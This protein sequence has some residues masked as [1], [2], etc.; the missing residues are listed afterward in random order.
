MPAISAK[1]ILGAA[2]LG[3]DIVRPRAPI[4]TARSVVR[5][6]AAKNHLAHQWTVAKRK[7]VTTRT[8]P[9]PRIKP[10][11]PGA[12]RSSNPVTSTLMVTI[13]PTMVSAKRKP[14]LTSANQATVAPQRFLTTQISPSEQSS[15]RAPANPKS[16]SAFH[17]A[18]FSASF[19]ALVRPA[20]L[21]N[22]CGGL[23][24]RGNKRW[25]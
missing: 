11:F 8:I 1:R 22:A 17:S 20:L 5:Q 18:A 24:T 21:A 12:P 3:K 25:I 2:I 7:M 10:P 19:K 9:I 16:N 14:D 4:T 15:A 6:Q 13:V 23:P